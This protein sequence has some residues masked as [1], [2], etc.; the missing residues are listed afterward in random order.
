MNDQTK[1]NR[2]YSDRLQDMTIPQANLRLE[3]LASYLSGGKALDLA[4]GLGANSLFLAQLDYQV[5][6]VDISEVAIRHLQEQ[7]IL[8]KLSINARVCDL[9][10]EKLEGHGPFDLIVMTY[11]LDRSLF[12]ALKPLIKDKGYLFIETFYQSP[13]TEGQGVSKQYK[14]LPK[15]LLSKFNDWKVVFFE[16]DELEGRQTIL[17]QKE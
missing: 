4:C 9:T 13:K 6:A 2:K 10:N 8:N 15:E 14:L 17:C 12:P 5:L 7:A 11:Y 1:W 3:K 16:E